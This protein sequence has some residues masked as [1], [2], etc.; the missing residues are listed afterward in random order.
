MKS[1]TEIFH[2]LRASSQSFAFEKAKKILNGFNGALYLSVKRILHFYRL[3]EAI[4]RFSG[5]CMLF[6][7]QKVLKLLLA[8][9]NLSSNDILI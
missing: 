6:A 4:K 7:T 1:Y 5:A 2:V 3:E 8:D 9:A